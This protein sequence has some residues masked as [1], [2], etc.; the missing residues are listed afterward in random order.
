MSWGSTTLGEAGRWVSGGTPSTS[1]EAFWGGD[2]PWMSSK[3]LTMFQVR[4]SDRRLTTLGAANGTKLVPVDTILMVVRGMSLKTEFRMG[5]TQ[6][7]VALS[8]DL[9]AL[10]PSQSFDPLF[11]AYSIKARTEDV[12]DM[13]DEAG[14]GTGRLQTDRLFSLRLPVPPIEE[15]RAI[16]ATLGALDDKIE[17]NRRGI[18][19]A[20]ELLDA[21]ADRVSQMLPNTPL[22]SLASLAKQSVNPT[23]LDGAQ[24]AHFSLPAFDTDARPEITSASTIKSNKLQVADTSVLVSRLNPRINR[25]WWAVPVAGL[26]AL[27][28][29]EFAVLTAGTEVELAGVWLAVRAPYFRDELP[30]RV[31]GTSGSHQRVRPEDL[32]SV[33]VPDTR[34]LDNETMATALRLLRLIHQW[35]AESFRLAALRD[36]LL[37]ELLSGRIRVPEATDLVQDAVV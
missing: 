28:S 1:N 25:T 35:R 6:R 20:G 17:S 16:A 23:A 7:Q 3:S 26:S 5:I 2:I 31:T 36:K 19:T 29:T 24:V 13:V 22:G 37:P 30:R 8:Q 14:H 12:L 9:K 27:S 18:G 33:E 4:D 10:L 15:Q 32:L 11:L 34:A 21:L